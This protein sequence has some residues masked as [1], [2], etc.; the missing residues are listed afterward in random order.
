MLQTFLI[1]RD[2]ACHFIR[3]SAARRSV[4]KFLMVSYIGS[5]RAKP[6][7]WDDEQ[8]KAAQAVNNGMLANYYKAKIAADEELFLAA[9][10]RGG[11]FAGIGLRPGTLTEEPKGGVLL[12]KIP[13]SRGRSSR[14]SVA[15]TAEALLATDGVKTSWIDILDGEEEVEAAVKKLVETGVDAVEGEPVVEKAV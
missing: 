5:R 12:G 3:A 4:S 10:K 8:W 9:K 11:G 14:A 7:W 1:D 6:A 2:A 13:V 15:A